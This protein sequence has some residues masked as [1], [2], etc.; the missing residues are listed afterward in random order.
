MASLLCGNIECMCFILTITG[1]KVSVTKAV[2]STKNKKV[3]HKEL[4]EQL[5]EQMKL[6][7]R[8]A[9]SRMIS[10]I[11]SSRFVS[12]D[13]GD[14]ASELT[15][16]ELEER[17]QEIVWKRTEVMIAKTADRT[18]ERLTSGKRPSAEGLL[19]QLSKDPACQRSAI[20]DILRQSVRELEQELEGE[21]IEV[22]PERQMVA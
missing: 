17:V 1:V 10:D 3:P 8:A 11:Y 2:V 19:W 13:A 9:F 12:V 14:G 22:S 4:Q 7:F 18:W 16:G 5:R 20:R 6:G 15:P 21:P